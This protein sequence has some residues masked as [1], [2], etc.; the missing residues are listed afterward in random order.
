MKFCFTLALCALILSFCAGAIAVEVPATSTSNRL[1]GL[2]RHLNAVKGNICAL[3][4]HC[5]YGYRCHYF[6]CIEDHSHGSCQRSFGRCCG[7]EDCW[8]G[9]H[10]RSQI[11]VHGQPTPTPAATACVAQAHVCCEDGN[12]PIWE[13]CVDGKCRNPKFCKPQS[14]RCCFTRDCRE[15]FFCIGRKCTQTATPAPTTTPTPFSP[16][17]TPT[18]TITVAPTP[19]F[20]FTITPSPTFTFTFAPTPTVTFT[21]TPTA[22]TNGDPDICLDISDEGLLDCFYPGIRLTCPSSCASASPTVTATA[23]TSPTVTATTTISP[24]ATATTTTTPSGGENAICAQLKALGRL[25]CDQEP[26][27]AQ[28]FVSCADEDR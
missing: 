10:C 28:C 22:T 5:A 13:V 7:H 11:C 15:G 18:V 21:F 12:C 25:Q 9:F 8:N 1:Q 16:S 26:V 24:T 27:R 23:T 14:G 3:Q 20:T 17:P 4:H 2:T 19:T 6:R